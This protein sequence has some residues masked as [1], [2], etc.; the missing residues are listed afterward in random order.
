[1]PEI[2]D[3]TPLQK[4]TAPKSIAFFGASNNPA[5]M[6]TTQ[7]R[8][9]LKMGYQGKVF[10][11]HPRETMVQGLQAY[12]DVAD[13]PEVPDLAVLILPTKVVIDI[14]DK[15]GRLGIKKAV[16]VSGGFLE[17]GGEGKTLQEELK[18][19]A[20]R[21]GIR[22]LGPN[23]L[24]LVNTHEK[25]NTTFFPCDCDPGF[26]G[27]VSQSGSFVTQ[28]FTYL[29]R[30]GLGF[31]T[32]FSVGNEAN[33]DLV[34]CLEHLSRDPETKVI[35][36]YI[37]A[38]RRGREFI[39]AARSI[40]QTKPI[41]AYYV[42]GSEAGR[43]AGLSHTGAMAGPDPLYEGIFRQAGVIRAATIEE[44]FDF[45][46]V[47][48]A[49]PLPQGDN[50]II[51]THSGGPGAACADACGREGLKLPELP[52]DLKKALSKYV[53]HTGSLRNPVDVTFSK[54]PM[55]YFRDMP[56]LILNNPMVDGLLI[57]FLLP[58]FMAE[59]ALE[60][61]GV[62]QEEIKEKVGEF[63]DQQAGG[64]ARMMKN[65]PKPVLG[66]S[67]MERDELPIQVVQKQGLPVLP[68]PER[69]ARAM[70]ALFLYKKLKAKNNFSQE[71]A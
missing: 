63:I 29:K 32:A 39:E 28:I 35:T 42:G 43:Q 59:Q 15:C 50:M 5:S 14:L 67:F 56:Q 52:L 62:P 6:G 57:Y 16:V 48:G 70:K 22:F 68:S 20:K 45:A 51:L 19:T 13:L 60:V 41:V 44:L 3:A 40:T 11:I 54:N 69:A 10:P 7:L 47:L 12:K 66:F 65:S 58:G 25:L 64:V 71:A 36:L 46:W 61:M 4:M 18:E 21:H 31:S 55:E 49:S 26:I 8:C 38:I 1:M 53:P 34:D 27:M 17:V 9:L 33:L 2:I 37:E 23:C 24:G 30:Y